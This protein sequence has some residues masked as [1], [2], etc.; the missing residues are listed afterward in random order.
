[1]SLSFPLL[2]L[3]A[4]TTSICNS[5]VTM[6]THREFFIFEKFTRARRYLRLVIGYHARQVHRQ[7]NTFAKPPS[8]LF[9]W[10]LM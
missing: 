6:S 5:A 10:S 2:S 4:Q 3:E 9:S 7:G 8:L 1:M